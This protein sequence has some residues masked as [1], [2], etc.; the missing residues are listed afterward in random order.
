MS[1]ASDQPAA[2]VA[3]RRRISSDTATLLRSALVVALVLTVPTLAFVLARG[4]G[5]A[6]QPSARLQ[7]QGDTWDGNLA[8]DGDR[9][10]LMSR[11]EIAGFWGV[12]NVRSSAD[13]GR[14]WGEPVRVSAEGG[15]SAARHTLTVGPDGSL[16]AAWAQ[17][18]AAPSTQQLMVR[19]SRDDGR[20]W[21][22]PIRASGADVGQVGIPALV[23]TPGL[24]FVA[25]TNGETGIVLVQAL[26]SDG[27]P[28]SGPYTLPKTT[29][30]L[31]D[32][33][34]FLD[35]G[36]GGA[37]VNGRGTLVGHDGQRLWRASQQGPG[38]PWLEEDWYAGAAYAQPRL[39]VAEGRLTALAVVLTGDSIQISSETSSNGGLS[40]D[41]GATWHDPYAGEASLAVAPDQTAVLWESCDQFCTSSILRVGNA[42]AAD[43]RAS[44][45][46]GSAGRPAGTLLTDDTMVVAW[47]E[48]G[49]DYEAEQRNLVVATGPRP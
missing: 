46:G 36:L 23:M 8:T 27:Q 6:W 7:V 14:T 12:L 38:W 48:E 26:D 11:E 2:G 18:G 43:G 9:V 35:A 4:A 25:F 49:P 44:R 34:P 33:S 47:I 24:S 15:P 39:S 41:T 22:S 3:P 19:R 28:V 17:Q 45:I 37:A 13:E 31:F 40:W 10:Y 32:D 1:A 16:W 5:P 30:P 42:A 20:T 21:E 29:R